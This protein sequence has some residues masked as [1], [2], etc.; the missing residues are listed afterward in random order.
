[1]NRVDGGGRKACIA[2]Q[3][4]RLQAS[5][6]RWWGRLGRGLIKGKRSKYKS[7]RLEDWECHLSLER[8]KALE[9]L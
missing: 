2:R 7:Q 9:P 8:A 5:G 6:K 3:P 4:T 1:M